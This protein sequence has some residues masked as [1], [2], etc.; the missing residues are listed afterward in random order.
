VHRLIVGIESSMLVLLTG[1]LDLFAHNQPFTKAALVILAVIA[2]AMVVLHFVSI[3][4]SSR[5]KA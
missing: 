2:I 3:V 4:L 5:L 1:V